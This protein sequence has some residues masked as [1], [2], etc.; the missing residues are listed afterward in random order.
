MYCIKCGAENS[1]EAVF[2]Q[3]CGNKFSV[4]KGSDEEQTRLAEA[5]TATVKTGDDHET[6]LFSVRPTLIFVKLGYALAVAGGFLLV[7]LIVVISNSTGFVVPAWISVIL[8]LSLLLIPAYFHIKQR[9]VRYVLT[10]SKVM[11]DRGLISKTTRNIPLKIIQDVTVSA[12]FFQR[13]LGFGDIEIEN[14]NESDDKI[15]LDNINNPKQ[16]A[17]VLLKQMRKVHK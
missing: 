4:E 15:V 12:N 10:D 16:A 5:R 9:T 2:C 13:A 1:D 11:I 8:G 14:A 6:E 3:K 7:A 17:E